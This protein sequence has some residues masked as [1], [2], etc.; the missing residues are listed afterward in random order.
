MKQCMDAAN[1]HR[2]LRKI[3]GQVNA[4]DKMVDSLSP[5]LK[6]YLKKAEKSAP[7]RTVP[8]KGGFL[9]KMET[10]VRLQSLGI[11]PGEFLIELPEGERHIPLSFP[12]TFGSSLRPDN[13]E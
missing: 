7:H 3:I 2:R 6:T 4:I 13:L 12:G 9:R 10:E 1:L 11:E 8:V 5:E